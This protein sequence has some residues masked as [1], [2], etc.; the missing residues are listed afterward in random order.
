[1]DARMYQAI[2]MMGTPTMSEEDL[3]IKATA[4]E[5]RRLRRRGLR[6]RLSTPR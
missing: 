6:A 3:A 1:M 4:I 5:A 2:D